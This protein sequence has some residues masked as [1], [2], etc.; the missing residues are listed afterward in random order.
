MITLAQAFANSCQEAARWREGK[1][2]EDDDVRNL[3]CAEALR[4]AATW[5]L[6]SSEAGTRLSEVLP[7]VAQTG[8]G[9]LL[10]D[11]EAQRIFAAYCFE[12]PEELDG[13][14]RRVADAQ[15]ALT[16]PEQYDQLMGDGT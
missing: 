13:W 4:T 15:Y 6:A 3:Q 12:A 10:L 2:S 14:L 16:Y 9:L 11:H 7:R 1:A 8:Q 5:A